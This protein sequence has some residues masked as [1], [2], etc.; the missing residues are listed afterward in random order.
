[1]ILTVLAPD[2]LIDY[3]FANG[4]LPWAPPI[5]V[6][7]GLLALLAPSQPP[8]PS[9]KACLQLGAFTWTLPTL[10]NV[11][12]NQLQQDT[13]HAS[14]FTFEHVT[15]TLFVW[16]PLASG[17]VLSMVVRWRLK[18]RRERRLA[19]GQTGTWSWPPG[20]ITA[21]QGRHRLWR[22]RK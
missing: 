16:L 20:P 1:M 21:F 17:I 2:S 8:P 6:T 7:M 10:V 5:F 4:F 22:T 13:R 11:V 3:A 19:Q 12:L 18:A 15:T 9:L 14:L